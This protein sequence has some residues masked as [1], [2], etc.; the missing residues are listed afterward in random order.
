MV[1]VYIYRY[2]PLST[3]SRP[4]PLPF[5]AITYVFG[6]PKGRMEGCATPASA[7]AYLAIDVIRASGSESHVS[8]TSDTC[9]LWDVI[10]GVP[11]KGIAFGVTS[12]LPRELVIRIARRLEGRDHA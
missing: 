2:G 11:A 12:T 9:P 8:T 1:E 5:S 3:T 6:A 10:G 7:P 4:A